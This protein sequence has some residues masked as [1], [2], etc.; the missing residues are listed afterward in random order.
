MCIM[1]ISIM[2]F[3][4]IGVFR[5]FLLLTNILCGEDLLAQKFTCLFAMQIKLNHGFNFIIRLS[6][7]LH[8]MPQ[9]DLH[10]Q[11]E[12]I[13]FLAMVSEV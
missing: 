11:N 1:C 12:S 2:H 7:I 4:A 5:C 13:R 3:D 6:K 9:H 10:W 8:T